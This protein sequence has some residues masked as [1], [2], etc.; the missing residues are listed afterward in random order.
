MATEQ[1]GMDKN[2]QLQ[3]SLQFYQRSIRLRKEGSLKE[4]IK[5][6]EEQDFKISGSRSR[7]LSVMAG[8]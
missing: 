4:P 2:L 3:Q 6:L 7:S 8:H 1:G 5:Y